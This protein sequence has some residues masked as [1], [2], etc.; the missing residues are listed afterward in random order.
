MADKRAADSQDVADQQM[1]LVFHARPQASS[2]THE[3]PEI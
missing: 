3:H 1:L 2:T